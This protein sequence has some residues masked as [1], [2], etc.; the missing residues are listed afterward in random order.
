VFLLTLLYDLCALICI[1]FIPLRKTPG[2]RFMLGLLV[3]LLLRAVSK[4]ILKCGST[5]FLSQA[6]GDLGGLKRLASEMG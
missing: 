5:A 3:V 2:R 1:V 4:E 6:L